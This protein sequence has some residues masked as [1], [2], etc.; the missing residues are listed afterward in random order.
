MRQG[1]S[2]PRLIAL[3]IMVACAAL[4]LAFSFRATPARAMALPEG[5][6]LQEALSAG[7]YAALFGPSEG[8]NNPQPGYHD[9]GRGGN[10]FVNDPCLDPPAPGTQRTVQSETEI[11][12]LNTPGS[13]GK[14]MVAGYNDS[15][16]FYNDKEGLSGFAYTVD[17]GNTWIDGGGLPPRTPGGDTEYYG[18]PVVVVHHQTQRFFYASIYSREDGTFTLSVNRGTFKVAP[19]QGIESIA[20]TRC[21][22]DGRFGIPAPPK[23]VQERMI[24]E[25]PVEAVPTTVN[26]Q[27]D[28]LDKEWLYVDQ[29]TGTLYLTYTRFED[30]L[31]A[32]TATP[33][34]L[35]RCLGCANNAAFT[36]ADWD[37][38]YE[39]VPNEVDTFNQAT[40][41]VTTPTGRVVVTFFSR[42][43]SAGGFGPEDQQRID[44]IYSDTDGTTFPASNRRVVSLVN[45]QGEPPG[46]NRGRTSILNA[47]YINGNKGLDD[48]VVTSSD[49]ATPGYGNLYIT[50]FSG[51]TPVAAGPPFASAADVFMSTSIDGGNTWRTP[52]KMND[53][54][55]TT[56]HVFPTVQVNKNGYVYADWL[57]RRKDA[58]N[59]LTD[60]WANV[61]KNNGATFGPDRLQT[62]VATGWFVRADARPNFGDYNS[63]DLVAFNDFVTIYADGR[64]P[65]PAPAALAATPDTIFTIANGLGVGNLSR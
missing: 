27:L 5:L 30:A 39:I 12:V 3:R 23:K 59:V 37:G 26:E 1:L 17:G 46:Y 61:S 6:P 60:Q 40:M 7:G 18:D 32:T 8:N 36:S 55:G 20:N 28:V 24:W 44:S 22:N 54:P 14:K 45:P 19:A 51:R 56:S 42:R 4:A 13:M 49:T 15:Y 47:P 65:P 21:L 38:P 57:D 41:P 2:R 63:S 64:F 43:F 58:T 53:D 10:T 34:E 31:A 35:M 62:D 29:K 11:A 33:L 16:G 25:P 9:N 50:Y 52:V 48:G